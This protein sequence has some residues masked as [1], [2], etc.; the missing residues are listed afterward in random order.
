MTF[1]L[2]PD[3]KMIILVS[4]ITVPKCHFCYHKMH[5]ALRNRS[6]HYALSWANKDVGL[7]DAAFGLESYETCRNDSM[8]RRGG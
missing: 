7:I 4:R 3:L 8:G 5:N 1:K 6:Y 2:G